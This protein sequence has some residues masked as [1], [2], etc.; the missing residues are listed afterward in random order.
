M[1]VSPSRDVI[2]KGRQ[3]PPYKRH[4]DDPFNSCFDGLV[5]KTSRCGRE[6]S[7]SIPS[8]GKK[9]V[10]HVLKKYFFPIGPLTRLKPSRL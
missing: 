1:G 10:F 5:V 4:L 8:R 6:D 7:G 9:K 2:K 3:P